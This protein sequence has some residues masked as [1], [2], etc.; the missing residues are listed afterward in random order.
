MI[1]IF[2]FLLGAVVVGTIGSV[3]KAAVE[4]G[5]KRRR[6]NELRTEADEHRAVTDQMNSEID[7]LRDRVSVLE[8]LATDE[9]RKL[10][11]EIERLRRDDRPNL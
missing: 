11:S 6:Y 10:A 4:G 8:R 7:R 1:G 2:D 9:D 5:G 3:A